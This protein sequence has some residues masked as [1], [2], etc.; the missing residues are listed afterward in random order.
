[1]PGP[2]NA[3]IDGSYV[4][5]MLVLPS[6]QILLT[7]LTDDIELYTPSMTPDDEERARRI[8]PVIYDAPREI[9]RGRTYEAS[10]IRFN[11]VTQG[12]AFGDDVQAATNYPLLRVTNLFT[13]HVSYCR[14][15][16]HSSMAVA[17]EEV[18]STH[19]DMPNV[20]E[21]GFSVLQVSQTAI[22][23]DPFLVFVE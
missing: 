3:S 12:A 23:S 4:G 6:G 1:M 13:A 17:S 7:D 22:A 9:S 19:F 15:H 18:V 14:T 8:A 11:G 16:D 10:G 21:P 2:P 20:L 5:D